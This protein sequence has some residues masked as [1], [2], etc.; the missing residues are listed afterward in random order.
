[1]CVWLGATGC[2]CAVY[3]G[4]FQAL[5]HF[6]SHHVTT[7]NP[8]LSWCSNPCQEGIN[9]LSDRTD[10][11]FRRLL[12]YKKSVGFAQRSLATASGRD[13]G[14]GANANILPASALPTDVDWRLKGAVTP[15][16][17][18]VCYYSFKYCAGPDMP[19]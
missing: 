15:V 16:K 10:A 18:L 5:A 11:E 3:G 13:A 17:D 14:V 19:L 12:G 7:L 8:R 1:M 2:Y 4:Y 6:D 9:H